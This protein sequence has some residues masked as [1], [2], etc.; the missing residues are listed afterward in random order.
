[1][2]YEPL[3]YYERVKEM[4]DPNWL[5]STC[6]QSAATIVAIMGGFLISK[7]IGLS[8]EKEGI[9]NQIADVESQT[10]FKKEMQNELQI[11]ILSADIEEFIDDCSFDI[12]EIAVGHYLKNAN[13]VGFDLPFQKYF[14]ENNSNKRTEEEL[15]PPFDNML[16]MVK[17]AIIFFFGNVKE[18]AGYTCS[19]SEFLYNNHI[20]I[21]QEKQSI[22]E[23][24]YEEITER[25]E[26]YCSSPLDR[27]GYFNARKL[28]P[29]KNQSEM[30]RYREMI[31]EW[32]RNDLDIKYLD[33][34]KAELEY[35]LKNYGKP[36]GVIPGVVVLTYFTFTGIIYPISLLPISAENFTIFQ[37]SLVIFL[38]I[39]GV[40]SVVGYFVYQIYL[41]KSIKRK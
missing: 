14:I 23:K 41:I 35:K 13:F 40:L 37:R 17:K 30:N 38:F 19:F 15:K 25:V 12:I 2:T 22:Y 10:K 4:P 18:T 28:V 1:M 26:E 3:R 24:V 11:K 32:E 34:Q 39:S 27:I 29:Q 21:P 6:S 36:K 31:V 7:I 5:L 9:I 20:E 33:K 16:E 8:S